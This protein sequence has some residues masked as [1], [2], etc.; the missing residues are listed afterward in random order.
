M[1]PCIKADETGLH[2]PREMIED[3]PPD[4]IFRVNRNGAQLILTPEGFTERTAG[5]VKY[6]EIDLDRAIDESLNIHEP[7]QPKSS[8]KSLSGLRR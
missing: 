2:I 4:T 7:T 3:F 6:Q 5:I 1:E 8:L